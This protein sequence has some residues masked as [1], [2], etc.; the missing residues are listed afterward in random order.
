MKGFFL[1]SLLYLLTAPLGAQMPD[2]LSLAVALETVWKNDPSLQS[3]KALIGAAEAGY[4]ENRSA[5]FPTL[6]AHAM[7]RELFYNAFNYREESAGLAAEWSPGN[8]LRKSAAADEAEIAVAGAAAEERRLV[9]TRKTLDLYVGILQQNYRLKRLQNN[10][11]VLGKHGEV[12]RALWEAGVR[13]EL[14]VL[15]TEIRLSQVQ[16]EVLTTQSQLDILKR[17]LAMLQGRNPETDFSLR[18][19]T[20]NVDD[21]DSLIARQQ[22]TA[23]PENNP[24]LRKTLEEQRAENLRL[25]KVSAT[26]FPVFQLDGGMV[27][28]RDP[29]ANGN[30]GQISLAMQLPLFEWGNRRYRRR[31]IFETSRALSLQYAGQERETLAEA[32][33]LFEE[34]H[35]LS[36]TYHQ[37]RF[38]LATSQKASDLATLNYQAGLLTNLE[39]LAAQNELNSARIQ[40]EETRLALLLKVANY[41]ALTGDIS[42]ITAFQEN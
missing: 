5:Y 24:T 18:A 6:V 13:T 33:Q 28:D 27:V 9:L 16:E 15:Q 10:L 3:R 26:A 41:C 8:W 14:D 36:Q 40:V 31:K 35:G 23:A 38:R 25:G 20:T 17:E 21:L 39:F 7:H 19:F 37:Q 1:L 2:S 42:K 30:Y 12:A 4:L 32:G 34:A 29:T 22:K 11:A